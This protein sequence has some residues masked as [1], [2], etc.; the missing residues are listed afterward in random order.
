[1]NEAK[2]Q[3]YVIVPAAGSST[4]MGQPKLLMPWPV[5]GCEDSTIIDSVLNA[6]TS[7]QV[8]K[9]VVVTRPNDI[10]LVDVC[11]RWSVEVVPAQSNPIDMKASLQIGLKFIEERL[12]PTR[13]D[14]VFIAPAD[15]PTLSPHIVDRLVRTNS[16]DDTIVV[17]VFGARRGHPVRMP[18][19]IAQKIHTLEPNEGPDRIVAKHPHYLVSFAENE[20]PKDIDTPDDYRAVSEFGTK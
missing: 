8:S 9:V 6:W 1:M 7:S 4:R 14:R 17:P 2:S 3:C 11:R 18:W 12:Q 10:D 13:R 5:A 15:I 19:R 20:R 16:K